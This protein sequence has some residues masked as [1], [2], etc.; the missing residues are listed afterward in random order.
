MVFAQALR[1]GNA[2][3]LIQSTPATDTALKAIKAQAGNQSDLYIRARRIERFAQQERCGRVAFV[4]TQPETKR[5]WP[6]LGGELNVCDDGMPPWRVCE[7]KTD[8]LVHPDTRCPN[9]RS[10]EDTE[11]VKAAIKRSL[12]RGALSAD[13]ARK[14]VEKMQTPKKVSP[15]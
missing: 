15:K 11:E 3:A 4:V 7:G 12:A 2:T 13:Q 6:G 9:G 1:E 10:A 5:V 14:E 8:V